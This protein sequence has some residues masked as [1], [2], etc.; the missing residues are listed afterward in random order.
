MEAMGLENEDFS[1]E[2]QCQC[3]CTWEFFA[4]IFLCFRKNPTR[5][6]STNQTPPW[7]IPPW[8]I[9]TW[10]IF[11]T[12]FSNISTQVFS[13]FFHYRHRYHWC[14]LKD[15]FVIL[16]FKSFYDCKNLSKQNVQW[17]KAINEMGGNIPSE[18]F[19]GGNLTSGGREWFS[20]GKSDGL[21]FSGG[22]F[23]GGNFP[24][25]IFFI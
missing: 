1:D 25:T 2:D 6:I 4:H 21:H 17:R 22:N 11:S 14:Y 7:W 3:L 24:R 12:M 20:R 15:C 18:S 23:P 10:N 5:K 13:F 16:C 8:K 9:P 19:M